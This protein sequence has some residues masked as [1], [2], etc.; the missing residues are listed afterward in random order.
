MT[1]TVKKVCEHGIRVV[2]IFD[3]YEAALAKATELNLAQ[4]FSECFIDIEETK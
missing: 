3:N 1:F 4:E 2:Q